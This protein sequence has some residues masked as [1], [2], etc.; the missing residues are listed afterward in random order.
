MV[1]HSFHM[2]EKKI[3]LFESKPLRE[4]VVYKWEKRVP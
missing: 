1:V 4:S 3:L 2:E